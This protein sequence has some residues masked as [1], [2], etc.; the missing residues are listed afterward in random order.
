M[1][2]HAHFRDHDRTGWH[3]LSGAPAH[4][5]AAV[6]RKR[7]AAGLDPILGREEL[8]ELERRVDRVRAEAMALARGPAVWID[9]QSRL[10]P[11][12]V[13][14]AG[15]GLFPAGGM[16][17]SKS[18]AAIPRTTDY[19]TTVLLVVGHGLARGHGSPGTI[20][21]R[22]DRGAYGSADQLNG[23]PGWT[24]RDGH[25]GGIVA[26][27]GPALRAVASDVVPLVV[28]W[29]PD[30]VRADHRAMVERIEKGERG[31]SANYIVEE[32]RT[33]RL[34]E[35]TDVIL[36]GRLVH[37]A[38]LPAGDA[39]AFPAAFATVFRMRPD[40]PAELRRQLAEVEKAARWRANQAEGSGR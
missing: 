40:T 11:K 24:L 4:I 36:R 13:A 10:A 15:N 3:P 20:G 35:P 21:K 16:A 17:A 29:T 27:A 6:N 8:L 31:V 22:I 38:L 39:P 32:R 9:P 26:L 28:Q 30:M 1:I 2:E 25:D 19:R 5:R 7:S 34:P 14:P 18:P 33:M 12:G 23:E 37:V